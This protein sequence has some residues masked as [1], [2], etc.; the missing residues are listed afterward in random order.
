[1]TSYG[2]GE[3][4]T[5]LLE[6]TIGASFER[7]VASYGDSEALVEVATGRRWMPRW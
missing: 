5:A 2:A 4:D 6:E 7:T 3:T 1:M